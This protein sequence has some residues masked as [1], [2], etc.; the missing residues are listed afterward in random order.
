MSILVLY[1]LWVKTTNWVNRDCQLLGLPYP[2]WNL[3]VWATFLVG[4]LAVI[5]IPMFAAGFSVLGLTYLIPLGAYIWKRNHEVDLHERVLTLNHLRHVLSHGASSMGMKLAAEGKAAHEKGAPVQFRPLGAD[6]KQNQANLIA[7]RQSPGFLNAKALIVELVHQR[8]DKC[9]LD[10]TQDAVSM[11]FQIDGVWHES[12]SQDRETGDAML[13]VF[14]RLASLNVEERRKR[15]TGRFST[16]YDGKKYGA[17]LISQGTETGE[18]VILQLDRPHEEFKT[19]RELGMREKPEQQLRELLRRPQGLV[20]FSSP[21][22]GG[23][24]TTVRLALDLT[25]R[26]MNDFVALQDEAAPEPLAENID[27]KTYSSAKGEVPQKILESLLRKEPNGV[28]M[29]DL[30]NAESAQMLCNHAAADKLVISTVRAK[31]AVEAL[32]RVLLL[33]VPASTFAPAIVA[34]LNT[35]LIR[36]LCD[37]CKQAY[38]P[39]PQLLKKL[40]IPAGR[41]EHLYRPPEPNEQDKVC[42]H[43][44]G[45]GYFGRTGI[46]ELLLV[47][48]RLREALEKQPKL[49]V[50]RL[51]AGRPATAPCSRKEFCS[52]L[53]E[54]RPFKNSAEC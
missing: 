46:F 19:L 39:T 20:L 38:E 37:N 15:M 32:L 49:D 26:Y 54:L 13:A 43:C 29:H 12:E 14:K 8:A 47:D 3:A 51:I 10:Y 2:I 11:R 31:E 24:T 9:M 53:R 33:K 36:R 25:D 34:V 1:F 44:N 48:D 17:I 52:S 6:V 42:P 27:L 35:R 40:G 30:P 4:L 45:I 23:L 41:I 50:L 22:Q 21:P 28:V 18:R 7:A 16:E 5:T